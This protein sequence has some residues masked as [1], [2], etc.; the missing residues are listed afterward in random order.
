MISALW[1]FSVLLLV[2]AISH[3][4]ALAED[5]PADKKQAS[6]EK[7]AGDKPDSDKKAKGDKDDDEL[8]IPPPP[9]GWDFKRP[10]SDADY[11]RKKRGSYVTGLP[12]AN[13]D[14]DT[15]VGGGVRG[16]YFFN[17]DRKH[18]LFGYTPYLHRLFAQYFRTTKGLQF[19]WA[20]YD[21]PAIAGTPY[22]L[23]A[24]AIYMRNTQQ[25]FFG[26]GNAAMD[27][28]SF[29]GSGQTFSE[30]SKYRRTIET[31]RGDGTALTRYDQ[32]DFVRPILLMSLEQ[33][34]L[35]GLIRPLVGLGFTH[36][37]ITDYTGTMVDAETVGGSEVRAPMGTTRLLEHCN[38][39]LLVGCEGGWDN[40]LRFGV[41]FDTRD[42][43]PDPNR[44]LFADIG[45][46]IGTKGL[47]GGYTYIRFLAAVRGYFSPMPKKADLVLAGRATFV[48]QSE[49]TPFF[50]MNTLPYTDEPRT[51]LGG[52]RTLRGFKQDRFFGRTMA[53]LNL[54]TR[55]TFHR[56]E[57]FNQK[58][59]LIGVV[60]LDTGRVFDKA[61]DL[62]LSKW[63][64]GVGSAFRI[65]W[66][67]ATIVTADYGVSRED[68]GLY[69]NFN[70]MF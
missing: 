62:T 9:K 35:R 50:S 53:L 23:R 19:H 65:A 2:L 39:G 5:K 52:L 57:L 34:F 10:L 8:E 22:R 20:D 36:T 61:A 41:A 12:L 38:A 55:W 42:F 58:F 16:Y 6:G 68:T 44:G 70:H 33:T 26:I 64:T 21:A 28:L 3:G 59:A 51:G 29:T 27:E 66:N 11:K 7:K 14:P 45:V 48:A 43:E 31:V 1:R 56:F 40:F 18:P 69:I 24:Q 49:N 47:G 30:F 67:Q 17:G 13:F 54:E 4:S 37:D 15:G 25:N 32:Y 60:F 46:D 63:R